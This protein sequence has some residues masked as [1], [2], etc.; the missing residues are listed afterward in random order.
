MGEFKVITPLATKNLV[1]NPS[2][3][4]D[5]T[6][7]TTA[8]SNSLVRSPDEQFAGSYSLA[9][10]YEDNVILT[11]YALTLVVAGQ[12]TASM[13]VYIPS[14]YGGSDI[15]IDHTAFTGAT[16]DS[17]AAADMTKV[18]QWQRLDITFTVLSSDLVGAIR[19]REYGS[20]QS[21]GQR[22]YIDAAQFEFQSQVTTYCD[23]DQENC[24]WLGSAHAS[25]SKRE[26]RGKS[27]GLVKDLADD[28]GLYL[29]T[30]N[31]IGLPAVS[32]IARNRGHIPGQEFQRTIPRT[33]V[34]RISKSTILGN[35][36]SGLH[37]NRSGVVDALKPD[38]EFGRQPTVFRHTATSVDKQ[39]KARYDTG[40]EFQ[41]QRGFNEELAIQFL[42]HDPFWSAVEETS[43]VMNTGESLGDVRSLMGRFS[44][45]GWSSMDV[46]KDPGGNG[47]VLALAVGDDGKVY[48]GGD[49]TAWNGVSG[50]DYAAAF[51]TGKQ[52]YSDLVL[53]T[54]RSNLIAYWPMWETSGTNA[55][56]L[57]GDS[58]LDGTYTS[59][60]LDN[61]TFDNTENP[62]PL[63]D[64][65]ADYLNIYTADLDSLL[66]RTRGTISIWGQVSGAG[67]WS[68]STIRYMIRL[69]VDGSNVLQLYKNSNNDELVASY[70]GGATTDLVTHSTSTT[71]W[72]HFVMTWDREAD[73]LKVYF[74][75]EQT[76]S[77]QTGLGN[78]SGSLASATTTIG[79][80]STTPTN[81]WDGNL[82]HAAIWDDVLTAQEILDLSV[83]E[84][85]WSTVGSS[86]D[87]NAAVNDIAIGFD[88]VVYF[89][90]NFTN[91][92]DANGDYIVS[93]DG[94]SFTSLGTPGSGITFVAMEAVDVG[95]DG[96]VWVG[97][98]WGNF[99]GVSDADMFAYWD[100]S[101]WNGSAG[102]Q[103]V[104]PGVLDLKVDSENVVWFGGQFSQGN[105]NFVA[106]YDV[107]TDTWSALKDGIDTGTAVTGV[108]VSPSGDVYFCGDFTSIDSDTDNNRITRWDGTRF[109]P[110][111]SGLAG[112]T[113]YSMEFDANGLLWVVGAHTEAGGNTRA[114]KISTWNGSIWAHEDKS[115]DTVATFRAVA[116]G[117]RG[118]VFA[119]ASSSAAIQSAGLTKVTAN[120][121]ALAYPKIVIKR[122]GGTS[123][124]LISI[125]QETTGVHLQFDLP[126][127]DGEQITVD[128]APGNRGVTSSRGSINK[129]KFLPSSQIGSFYLLPGNNELTL[130]VAVAGDPTVT[131]FLVF[132]EQYLSVDS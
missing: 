36:L 87:F 117:P 127:S 123:A 52:V 132:N 109:K 53:S 42:A 6:G 58:G 31:G 21:A 69:R 97:G 48:I 64:G 66:D 101:S 108:A 27:G 99:A 28:L 112:G 38:D 18:D 111:G 70:S 2:L 14:T 13:Y 86:S 41:R 4:L 103:L 129:L 11:S 54:K 51:D 113:P 82:A 85:P 80:A 50:R 98:D 33:R 67:V 8:G 114:T 92:G 5:T 7:W 29:E 16:G 37:T 125:F 61:T 72:F 25:E 49:F 83:N 15:R 116:T 75:G 20:G 59:V 93:W 22:L 43:H 63:W 57:E 71:G 107:D 120:G 78:F 122:T 44:S 46:T 121:S 119:G 68:D 10:I 47:D 124:E 118:Q 102:G 35:S 76:G 130:L 88:G 106:R 24:F 95:P 79:A 30:V 12:Y 90:G 55:D 19:I 94:N 110:L 91:V 74:D 81:V 1:T 56:N 3:E 84:N 126:I 100:G 73:E 23:G 128:F 105:Y 115:F 60:S 9:A 40:L 65:S 39:L 17:S 62:A 77:T 96:K 104:T 45:F 32:N 89:A 131:A 26:A 34:F